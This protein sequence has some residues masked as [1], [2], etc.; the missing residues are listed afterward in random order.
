M[1]YDFL[2]IYS[3]GAPASPTSAHPYSTSRTNSESNPPAPN[4]I[5]QVSKR[6]ASAT[7]GPL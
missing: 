1:I 2:P 7:Q 6:L 4:K 3:S 5:P